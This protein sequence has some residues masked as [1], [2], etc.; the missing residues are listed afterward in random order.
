VLIQQLNTLSGGLTVAGSA[1]SRCTVENILVDRSLDPH[2][3]VDEGAGS[4]RLVGNIHPDGLLRVDNR[5]G[6]TCYMLA[7]SVSHRPDIPDE[8]R[9]FRTGW[10]RRQPRGYSNRLAEPGGGIRS[11]TEAKC[12]PAKANAHSGRHV[13]RIA[14]LAGEGHAYAYFSVF[15]EPLFVYP[16]SCLRFWLF[17]VNESGRQ[18][19]V[20]LLF[21][22]GSTLRDSG[23]RTTDGVA[24]HP[25][26]PKGVVGEWRQITIPLTPRHTG[27]TISKVMVAYDSQDGV[28]PFEAYVDDLEI[29]FARSPNLFR[30]VAK[31]P[32]GYYPAPLTVAVDAPKKA[33]VRF[34]LDGSSPNAG[35]PIAGAP[36]TLRSP[37]LWDFRY[38]AER[39]KGG[40]G[41]VVFGELYEI[42]P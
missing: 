10:E 4:V 27:K 20:D 38:A 12:A 1:A 28:G 7:N 2:I 8:A 13:L 15:E 18:V 16:T 9:R 33:R 39:R 35:S 36:V 31:P 29:G 23:T 42:G 21:S 17:A 22:D 5:A 6:R 11:V 25:A 37:G 3:C 41:D 26:N 32:G 34:T 19:S 30:I 14:G 40:V 24:A